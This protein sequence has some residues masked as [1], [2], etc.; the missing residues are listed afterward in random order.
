MVPIRNGIEPF[1]N[2]DYIG[3]PWR[4]IPYNYQIEGI[5]KV[6]QVVGNGGL[7]LRS[8]SKMIEA[9][10]EFP[11]RNWLLH[12][13]PEDVYYASVFPAM[14]LI[15]QIQKLQWNSHMKLFMIN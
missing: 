5:P 15:L 4:N 2:Y 9:L 6:N 14:G 7:S 3:A 11:A 10:D 1:L 12:N 8:V 13:Y